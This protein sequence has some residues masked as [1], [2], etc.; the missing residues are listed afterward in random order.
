MLATSMTEQCA[1]LVV[2]VAADIVAQA[3]S[4]ASAG[5]STRSRR[6]DIERM[7]E[8]ASIRLQ[9]VPTIERAAAM[10]M[11]RDMVWQNLE[12]RGRS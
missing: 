6:R 10:R 4:A 8:R 5:Q 1:Q 3:R 7:L 9:H 2:E 12:P 11:V